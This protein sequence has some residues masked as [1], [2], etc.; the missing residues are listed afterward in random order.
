[1]LIFL[2]IGPK[3]QSFVPTNISYWHYRTLQFVD[4]VPFS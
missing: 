2:W 3:T 4:P 1:M